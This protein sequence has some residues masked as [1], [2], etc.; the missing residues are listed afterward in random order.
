MKLSELAGFLGGKLEGDP[1]FTITGI[2]KIEEA[3]SGQVTFI[4]NSKY[5]KYLS[6]TRAQALICSP[7]IQVPENGPKHVIRVSDPYTAF[8][9]TLERFNPP[10]NWTDGGIHPTAQVDPS[11]RLGTNVTLGPGVVVYKDARIGNNT[12]IYANSVVG[13][14]AS[15]GEN[16]LI[17][18]NVTVYHQVQIHNRVIIHSGT[19]I[20]SDGFG[21]VPGMDGV[22][23]KIPQMGFVILEDDVEIG[24]NT[25]VD[26]AT[27]GATVIKQGTKLDNLIQ[28]A[29]NVNI[30]ENTV[31]AA[32]VGVAGS[33]KVG[34]NCQI[35]G[36]VGIA[37]HL[38][39]VNHV[40]IGAQSGVSKSL[41][42]PGTTYF[43]TPAKPIKEAFRLE[44]S[45][46]QLPALFR[47]IKELEDK[48]AALEAKIGENK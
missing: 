12:R 36:Q 10:L 3:D 6:S 4:S 9:F 37:G 32:Q 35:G 18:P 1:E 38:E 7:D 27:L 26:R 17:Y 24:A 40:S 43:G 21:F 29:H 47:Q 25:A 30:G 2:A 39:V 41:T 5:E 42:Q 16:C 34:S 45:M 22:Y 15:I 28:I 31:L 11:A 13:P 33:V 14:S 48:L 44:G 8:L 20:G 46:R 19:V 23:R